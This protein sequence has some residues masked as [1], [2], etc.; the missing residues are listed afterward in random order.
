MPRHPSEEL[1]F[2]SV[3]GTEDNAVVLD[4]T[5]MK[6][7]GCSAAV[8]RMLSSTSGVESAAVNLLTGTAALTVSQNATEVGQKAAEMLSAKVC[9]STC[10]FCFHS[11]LFCRSLVH[12]MCLWSLNFGSFIVFHG[13]SVAFYLLSVLHIVPINVLNLLYS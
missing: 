12:C 5:G 8:K 7:G 4:V 9:R 6:C 3:Q 11:A 2:G 1:A 10:F 13:C